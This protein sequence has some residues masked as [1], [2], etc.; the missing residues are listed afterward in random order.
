MEV[1]EYPFDRE[2]IQAKRRK[3]KKELIQSGTNFIKKRIAILGG[4]T[5]AGI[6]EI[7]EL[8][9][10]NYG[11]QPDFYESA[12]NKFFED[13]VFSNAELDEFR[14][15]IAYICTSVR[16]ISKWPMPSDNKDKVNS[17]LA[18]EMSKYK[19]IWEALYNRF[20]CTIVQNNFDM[21]V[22]RLMGNFDA[23][24]ECGAVNYVMRLNL[25][26]SK[27]VADRKYLNLV[28]LNYISSDY[29]LNRW[30]DMVAWYSYKYAMSIDAI[31]DL[32]FNIANVIKALLGKNKKGIALDLD[33]TLWGGII[34]D[35]GID[36]IAL[37]PETP[38]GQ[39]YQDFQKYI[40]SHTCLGIV[41]AVDSKNDEG[42]A[43]AGLSH[44][45]S[46]LSK[47]DFAC[48]KAN[49]NPK[50]INLRRIATELSLGED[51]FVFVDDN[52]AERMIVARNIQ[53]VSIPELGKVTDYIKIIDHS[54]FFETVA[55]S[56][57]DV[58]RNEMYKENAVRTNM[59]S[60]YTDYGEYLKALEMKAVIVPF[61]AVYMARITQLTNKSNQFNL[62]TR[63]YTQVEM[64]DAAFSKTSVTLCGKLED[65]FG[66][67]GIVTVA[68]G[69]IEGAKCFVD[70]WCMSCRVLRRDMEYA[71]MDEFISACKAK[72]V[73]I[74][75]GTYIPTAKNSIVKE[76]YKE[77]GFDLVSDDNGTTTWKL[78]I[79]KDIPKKNKYI[80]IGE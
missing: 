23:V 64:E 6:K 47:E 27:E 76:F 50:D 68:M 30:H 52:P 62:T 53:G 22:Y 61:E 18:L 73:K 13:A 69:H 48:F 7:L 57:D 9:L 24:D 58:K 17:L 38:S 70:L 79:T 60:A 14:P 66:D 55:I 34:G 8:F 35:D 15:E 72:F 25:M 40:K 46:V 45:S 49:W 44:P 56:A 51:S 11:I 1:L 29:G 10:L 37:G 78:D 42:N 31:P 41:L 19:N 33:N 39:A 67:N 16:N 74:I 75:V 28:D 4:S 2:F 20:G 5:T 59:E 65:K 63:R 71:M 43:M 26:I 3:I 12:Y 32:A 36:N 80:Q 77:M 54:G 21:P